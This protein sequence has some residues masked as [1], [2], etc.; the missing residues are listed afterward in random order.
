[1]CVEG[2][3]IVEVKSVTRL[4]LIHPAQLITYFS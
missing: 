2:K 1:M 4:A 3:V